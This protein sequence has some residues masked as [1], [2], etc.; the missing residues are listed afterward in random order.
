MKTRKALAVMLAVVMLVVPFAVSSMAAVTIAG[1]ATKTAYTDAE[2]FNPQGLVVNVDGTRIEYSATDAN[3]R[4]VPALN[5]FLSVNDTEVFVYYRNE[6]VGSVAIT[7][8]HTLGEL[9]CI[10][11]GHGKYCLGC[12]ELC[13]FE[14]HVIN[15][16]IPNDDGGV[17]VPQ[18]QT[19]TC[20]ICK[21]TFTQSIPGSEHFT[22]LF[23]FDT[24]TALEG[25]VIGYIYQIAVTL[26]Q[27]LV[28]IY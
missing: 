21:G 17:F 3:F 9:T 12:G 23:D 25:T 13:D 5:E 10:D 26:I 4:F 2:C 24:M 11:N 15:E 7:V 28:G 22:N 14:E 27:M 1:P 18:T 16:W 20:E 6:L 19:G 8:E